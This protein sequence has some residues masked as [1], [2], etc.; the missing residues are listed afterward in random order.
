MDIC[1][2]V[3]IG[4][5][6]SELLCFLVTI[7]T[8]S[9]EKGVISGSFLFFILFMGIKRIVKAISVMYIRHFYVSFALCGYF[10]WNDADKANKEIILETFRIKPKDVSKYKDKYDSFVDSNK[11]R[12]IYYYFKRIDG[13]YIENVMPINDK[14]NNNNRYDYD[15]IHNNMLRV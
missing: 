12:V 2:G 3:L 9:D 6:L 7:F 14:H 10:H 13:K 8:D 5:I 4:F 15:W 11:D 1:I